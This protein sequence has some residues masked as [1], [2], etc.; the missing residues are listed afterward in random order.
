MIIV[1]RHSS[2]KM[3]PVKASKKENREKFYANL[4][5]DLIYL[6]PGKPTFAIGGRVRISKYKRAV[7]DKG[8]TPNWTEQTF[9][10]DEVLP[11]KPVTYKKRFT[12][13]STRKIYKKQNKRPL[14]WRKFWNEITKEKVSIGEMEWIFR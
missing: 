1:T 3:T 11:T 9:V 7:F 10:D 8:Y 13:L 6:N 4:Y 12:H 2:I 5:Q 14:E